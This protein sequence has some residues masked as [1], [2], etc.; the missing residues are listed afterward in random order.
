MAQKPWR[1]IQFSDDENT[2]RFTWRQIEDAVRAVKERNEARKRNGRHPAPR[3]AGAER[4]AAARSAPKP[5]RAAGVR[6]RS[7]GKV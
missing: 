6:A 7:K 1:P 4:D 3:S 5:R 2:G